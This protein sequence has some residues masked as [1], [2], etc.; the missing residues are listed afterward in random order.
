MDAV[1]KEGDGE[2]SLLWGRREGEM[3]NGRKWSQ[4]FHS[5]FSSPHIPLCVFSPSILCHCRFGSKLAYFLVRKN[6]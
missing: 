3:Q 4:C 5:I 6:S 2:T 1:K